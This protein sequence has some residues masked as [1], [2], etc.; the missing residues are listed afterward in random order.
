[1]KC[2]KCGGYM[3]LVLVENDS[4]VKTKIWRCTNL[5]CLYMCREVTLK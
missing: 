4:T 1:M 5:R 3:V 2:D